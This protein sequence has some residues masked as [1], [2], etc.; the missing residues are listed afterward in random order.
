MGLLV[1][2]IGFI[3]TEHGVRRLNP[4]KLAPEHI[5]DIIV[6]LLDYVND[7]VIF[8]FWKFKNVRYISNLHDY[9]VYG[10]G[11]GVFSFGFDKANCRNQ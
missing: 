5:M 2:T 6:H 10:F 4:V 8:I 9:G 7:F 3:A 11:G 1:T